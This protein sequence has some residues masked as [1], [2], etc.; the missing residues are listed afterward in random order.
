M[1]PQ[2]YEIWSD[3]SDYPHC[4]G[5]GFRRFGDRDLIG[6]VDLCGMCKPVFEGRQ[7]AEQVID[8]RVKE[9]STIIGGDPEYWREQLKVV[10]GGFGS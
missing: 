5:C 1:A 9:I 10:Q 6:P 4:P 7:T 3:T 8:E 2:W